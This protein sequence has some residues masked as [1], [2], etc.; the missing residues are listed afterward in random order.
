MVLREED[1]HFLSSLYIA[2]A[3][4]FTWKGLWTG[5]Y[6]IPFIGSLE[7]NILGPY[8]GSFVFLFLGFAMLIFSGAIF[9]EF[10]PLG[11]IQNAVN[12]TLHSIQ[13]HHDKKNFEFKYYDKAQKKYVKIPAPW[14]KKIEKGALVAVHPH[15]KQE[16]FI[17]VHRVTEVL[18]KGKSYWRL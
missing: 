18:Y 1:K 10:D 11:G 13:T 14:V 7:C 17:P 5:I 8:C 12:K 2:I 9:K 15:Q 3:I 6:E 16:I 4:I